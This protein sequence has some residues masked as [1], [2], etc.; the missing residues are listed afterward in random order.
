MKP[1]SIHDTMC[2]GCEARI[3][4]AIRHASMVLAIYG[5]NNYAL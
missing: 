4:K 3:M 5:E 1:P 2:L